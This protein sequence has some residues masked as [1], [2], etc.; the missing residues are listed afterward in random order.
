MAVTFTRSPTNSN[1]IAE[2][3]STL[4]NEEVELLKDMTMIQ[5]RLESVRAAILSMKPLLPTEEVA[6][7]APIM[8]RLILRQHVREL[9]DPQLSFSKALKRIMDAQVQA[10][11]TR[12]AVAKLEES[13]WKFSS[14][15][16]DNKI[17]QVGVTFRRFEES[18]YK[19]DND[20]KWFSVDSPAALV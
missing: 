10:L 20:G 16:P 11:T 3:Y 13:G 15:I 18:Q 7:E 1:A 9:V 17:N 6:R 19:R 14:D 12:E 2:A 8:R 5:A 4:R